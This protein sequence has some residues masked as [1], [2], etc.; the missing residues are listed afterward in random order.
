GGSSGDERLVVISSDSHVGPSMK[1]DLRPYCPAED[2]AAFDEYEQEM[3]DLR[4]QISAA[5]KTVDLA[6]VL[7]EERLDKFTRALRDSAP[8]FSPAAKKSFE[9]SY[10]CP[11]L[12]DA[13][14][15]HAD[16][17]REGVAADVL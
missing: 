3:A 6:H 10:S 7:A 2:L 9:I 13:A 12:K 1:D 8:N 4:D 5:P 14:V 16:M 17:D 11:G 15:R